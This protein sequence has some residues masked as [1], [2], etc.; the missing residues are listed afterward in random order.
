M[1]DFILL[2]AFCVVWYAGFYCG[3]TF[4]TLTAM[5]DKAVLKVRGWL[6]SN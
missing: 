2:I 1:V 5:F 6:S 3:K 4:L